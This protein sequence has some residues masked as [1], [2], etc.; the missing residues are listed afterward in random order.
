MKIRETMTAQHNI[1]AIEERQLKWFEL[2]E[3]MKNNRISK[4]IRVECR[5]QKKK[6]EA[7]GWSKSKYNQ[8]ILHIRR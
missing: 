7:K 3:R 6:V 2:L 5:R 4:T 1:G 8:E